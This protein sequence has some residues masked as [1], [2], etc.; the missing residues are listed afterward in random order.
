MHT[1]SWPELKVQYKKHSALQKLPGTGL[2]GHTAHTAGL[3]HL[4][5]WQHLKNIT[6][7][8][9]QVYVQI[10]ELMFY[11]NPISNN[12]GNPSSSLMW[13]GSRKAMCCM[14]KI[15]GL[16][17]S[18]QL[19][20]E[21]KIGFP[22]YRPHL[23]RLQFLYEEFYC[24]WDLRTTHRNPHLLG[25]RVPEGKIKKIACLKRE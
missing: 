4:W 22:L 18:W 15:T 8:L 10:G 24:C 3:C 9:K 20:L 19:R 2:P 25:L 5:L 13:P 23:T 14:L 16:G 11:P 12:L 7:L 6:L 1:S 21:R 17:L